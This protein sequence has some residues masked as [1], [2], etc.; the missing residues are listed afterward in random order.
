[1]TRATLKARVNWLQG[2][3]GSGKVTA[4]SELPAIV[5]T[6]N[7][8]VPGRYEGRFTAPAEEGYYQLETAVQIPL[9]DG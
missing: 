1:M 5:L 3:P 4:L 7:P 2:L 8:D 9:Q 6:E